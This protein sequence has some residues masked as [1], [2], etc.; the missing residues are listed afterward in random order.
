MC[1]PDGLLP[2]AREPLVS[3]RQFDQPREDQLCVNAHLS[4]ISMLVSG[5][6]TV[7]FR[8]RLRCGSR[9]RVLLLTMVPALRSAGRDELRVILCGDISTSFRRNAT[10]AHSSSSLWSPQDGIPVILIPCLM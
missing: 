10:V 6:M 9:L 2:I 3:H 4:G 5:R 7:V 8:V 1:D